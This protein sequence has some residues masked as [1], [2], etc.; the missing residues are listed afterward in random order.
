[1]RSSS[2]HEHPAT[3]PDGFDTYD[4]LG[5]LELDATLWTPARLPLP[6]GEHIRMDPTRNW[7]S[8]RARPSCSFQHQ[9]ADR[10]Q[11]EL[12]LH[13]FIGTPDSAPGRFPVTGVDRCS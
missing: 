10:S 13:V 4:E 9:E 3:P 6:T 5:G 8:A 12:A 11:D 2:G 7:P 1:M